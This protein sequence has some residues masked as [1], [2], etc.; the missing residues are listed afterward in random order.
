MARGGGLRGD[1]LHAH[2]STAGDILMSNCP[3]NFMRDAIWRDCRMRVSV[4][5]C[6][7]LEVPQSIS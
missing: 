3:P 7:S 2:I 1:Q 6:E 5:K 4:H